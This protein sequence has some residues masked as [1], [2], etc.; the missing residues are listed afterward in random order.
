M[1]KRT[2]R[3]NIHVP[4]SLHDMNVIAFEVNGDDIIMRTQ[5]GLVK[6]TE[7][8]GQPDGY[9]EFHKVD[10]DFCYAYTI[11]SVANEGPFTGKKKFLKDFIASYQKA[12]FSIIDEVFGYNQTKFFGW[13]SMGEILKECIIEIYHLGDMVYVTEE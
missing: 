2:I 6:T 9:V 13:L 3:E 4:Y 7:P 5:S 10:W 8:Y 12:S 1:M 11:N